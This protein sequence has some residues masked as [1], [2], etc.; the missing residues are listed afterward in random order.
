MKNIIIVLFL[1][2]TFFSKLYAVECIPRTL[3]EKYGQ[4]DFVAKVKIKKYNTKDEDLVF[5][6]VAVEVEIEVLELFKGKTLNTFKLYTESSMN[7]VY[8]SD[9]STWLI[10]A[11]YN[12]EEKLYH[13]ECSGSIQLTIS[14]NEVRNDNAQRIEERNKLKLDVLRFL[15]ENKIEYN[16]K[17]FLLPKYIEPCQG[18]LDLSNLKER[19]AIY[20]IK[21]CKNWTVSEIE[22]LK[23]F[24]KKEVTDYFYNCIKDNMYFKNLEK[25]IE[26]NKDSF[27]IILIY[28]YYPINEYNSDEEFI[29]FQDL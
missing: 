23:E 7:G 2:V 19:F 25:S 12:D 1:F 20:K 8:T 4:S 26:I 3:I 11:N 16:N 17:H 29:S 14:E 24:D 13:Y 28:Y 21:L 9:N 18:K 22:R 27:N 10:F 6:M 15:K 5:K